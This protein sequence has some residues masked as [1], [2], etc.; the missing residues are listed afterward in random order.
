MGAGVQVVGEQDG[1]RVARGAGALLHRRGDR[2]CVGN[3]VERR[4]PTRVPHQLGRGGGGD[5]LGRGFGELHPQRGVP[6]QV[7]AAVA[8][9]ALAGRHPDL[10]V[11]A[12]GGV[13]DAHHHPLLVV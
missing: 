9:V 2:V 6:L 12:H 10:P 13:G 3:I 4:D 7:R 5:V 8:P 1:A 11:R